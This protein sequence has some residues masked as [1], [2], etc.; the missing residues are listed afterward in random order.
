MIHAIVPMMPNPSPSPPLNEDW[1]PKFTAYSRQLLEYGWFVAPF[2][3]GSDFSRVEKVT[4]EI[5]R[6]PTPNQAE[7]EQLEK[8]IFFSLLDPVFHPNWRARA[9]WFGLK[10]D[11]FK[12]FSHL[13][14]SGIF[15]YYKREYAATI[16]CLLPALEGILLSFAG[17]RLGDTSRA[18]SNRKLIK[19]VRAA[20]RT[21]PLVRVDD[22]DMF[23]DLL[24]DFLEKWIYVDTDDA[25]FSL[26]VLNRHYV[27]H[28]FQPGNFYR[29]EDVHRLILL[30]DLLID[31]L[32]SNQGVF[33]G[34]FLPDRGREPLYDKRRDYY[35]DLASNNRTLRQCWETERA[36]LRDHP[37]YVEPK[38]EADMRASDII[39]LLDQLSLM[40]K[41]KEIKEAMEANPNPTETKS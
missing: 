7:R 31:F 4:I 21:H 23:R 17:W 24:A 3:L 38:N 14:E 26:S 33:M 27:L 30:F 13:Y 15:S 12:E 18:L 37:R 19:S 35:D 25:D 28:G 36:F 16:T 34:A 10:L 11:H 2:I 8:H 41:V 5:G 6:H 40:S 22:H 29:P 1:V 9:V 39:A 32:A 20:R